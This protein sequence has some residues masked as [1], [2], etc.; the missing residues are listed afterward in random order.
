MQARSARQAAREADD[1][2]RDAET[3]DRVRAFR[4]REIEEARANLAKVLDF[5]ELQASGRTEEAAAIDKQFWSPRDKPDRRV[6]NLS[7]LGDDGLVQA[8]LEMRRD[9]AVGAGV[10]DVPRIQNMRVLV[11]ALLDAQERA[12]L[13]DEPPLVIRPNR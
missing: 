9:L 4:I 7:L 12:A 10:S 3:K 11:M 8:F 13:A 6:M 5:H 1:R 2:K